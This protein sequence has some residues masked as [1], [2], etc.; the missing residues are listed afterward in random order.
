MKNIKISIGLLIVLASFTLMLI[1]SSGL[2]LNFL[3]RSNSDIRT[4]SYNAGEQK[5]LN[6]VRDAIINARIIIDTATQAKIHGDD[7][8]EPAVQ[9]SVRKEMSIADE[10]YQQFMKIPGLSTIEPDV[11]AR[12]KERYDQQIAVI[13][14]NASQVTT[15]DDVQ[16]LKAEYENSHPSTLQAR[17]AWDNEYQSYMA[18]TQRNLNK[19]IQFSNQSYHFALIVMLSVLILS[20]ILFLIVNIWMR[21]ILV[22][23]L[24]NVTQHFESIGKG[25]LTGEIHVANNN[26]IGQLFASLQIMQA[27]LNSTVVSIRQGVES[28]N[29]GTQEIAAGNS[30]L[31][32]RTEEQAAAVVET[33]ASMEQIS[34]TVKMNTDN[35]LQAS[36][37]VQ[38]AAG[39][40]T[41]GEQQMRHMMEK[42]DAISQSA[43]KMFEIISVIDSIAFQTNILALNAAV[44]AAR[45][46]QSGRGF[47]VVAEEVR[48]LARRC[49]DSAKEI[50]TLINQSTLYIQ[51]GA[52]LAT[53]TSQTIL[54]ISTAV[55]KVNVVM[56]NIAMASEEQSRGV[57]QIRVA[58]TQMDHVTQQNAALV[59]EVATTASGVNDQAHLLSQSVS[60]FKVKQTL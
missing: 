18:S 51:E 24:K 26:E 56:E 55:S 13:N 33:A 59:E 28:I 58:I 52:E 12:M 54:D 9:E 48:N 40:A 22:R 47:A 57:E 1:I 2:G 34:S 38:N 27:E 41:E 3:Y 37:M 29:I 32:R 25:D 46:G 15:I 8:D 60:L 23:P 14:R 4:L 31:S 21:N 7:I 10:H 42:M 39:I 6:S 20:A 16:E 36:Q 43:Q 17:Q 19:V 44:E 53:K 5:A 30:D 49:T 35:A 11:G 45:A 50:T